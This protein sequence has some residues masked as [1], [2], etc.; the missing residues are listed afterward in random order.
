MDKTYKSDEANNKS[1]LF[2]FFQAAFLK[3]LNLKKNQ[4]K[5]RFMIF[6]LILL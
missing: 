1:V 2:N 4:L 6:P 3:I 5:E